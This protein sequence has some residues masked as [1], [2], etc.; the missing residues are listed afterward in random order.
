[1][2]D[3]KKLIEAALF[4]AARPM[5]LAELYHVVSVPKPQIK[6]LLKEMEKE[7]E[8]H[9]LCVRERDGYFELHIKDEYKTHVEHLA[10]EKD[11][12]KATLQ[13]LSLIAY[14]NPTRQSFV[15]ETRGNRA[16]DH[17]KELASRG[18]IRLEPEGHT[19]RIHVTKKFLDY[20]N[21]TSQKEL[22]EYFSQRGIEPP[23]EEE[24]ERNASKKEDRATNTTQAEP[25]LEKKS[26]APAEPV[27]EQLPSE[28][29][30]EQPPPEAQEF[31]D[32]SQEEPK[33]QKDEADTKG[34]PEKEQEKSPSKEEHEN[35]K[36]NI[37]DDTQEIGESRS[38]EKEQDTKEQEKEKKKTAA[39]KSVNIKDEPYKSPFSDVIK[40]D[41][42]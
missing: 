36:K 38:Q 17:I 14:H 28:P 29:E 41:D 13:T 21:L 32:D 33:D 26:P 37:P 25:E 40:D 30:T 39:K 5:T 34:T 15:I 22:K 9:S 23:D 35:Q 10:P 12:S 4:I 19:N 31:P 11:F 20:F 24:Y 1:M 42:N 16:Y 8:N 18:F 7:Y 2:R 27:A 3:K 6:K